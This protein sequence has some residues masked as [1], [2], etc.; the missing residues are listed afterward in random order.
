MLKILT[1]GQLASQFCAALEASALPV[2]VKYVKQAQQ[3][4]ID[5]ADCLACF[6][7]SKDLSLQRVTWIHSFGAG[8][9]GFVARKDLHPQLRLSRTTGQLGRKMGEFCLTHL[10]NFLQNTVALQQ[11]MALRQW[12][13]RPARGIRGQ[14]VL[15]LGT[16]KMA[17]GVAQLLAPLGATIIG[18]NNRGR[19][20]DVN[21]QDCVRM[22]DVGAIA[23]QV[24]CIIN[25]LPLVEQTEGLID[26]AWLS[27]FHE[28]LLINVGRGAT[29]KTDDLQRAFAERYLA[30][31]V[32]DVFEHEPLPQDSW[33][34]QHPQVLVSPHQAAITDVH[35]VL[36]SFTAALHAR[37]QGLVN[38]LFIDVAK[39]Y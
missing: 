27:R 28:A 37:E 19:V 1:T 22:Q 33:L 23:A 21:F 39:G 4:D 13:Q 24:S 5:W 12:Q 8:V 10:L 26:L 7:V 34:W 32:L 36:T 2:Q 16:G 6:P 38:D 30:Y 20:D 15:I 18:V 35:D 29:V 31:G 17:Q 25:T 11:D 3:S 9:D 14:H